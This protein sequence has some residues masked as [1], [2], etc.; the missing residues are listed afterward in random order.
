MTLLCAFFTEERGFI[1]S[2]T[3]TSTAMKCDAHLEYRWE[4]SG[5]TTKFRVLPHLSAIV[6]STGRALV[7]DDAKNVLNR[8]VWPGGISSVPDQL[9]ELLQTW[10]DIHRSRLRAK[11]EDPGDMRAR[12]WVMGFDHAAGRVRFW[13]FD[14]EEAFLAT[15]REP[16]LYLSPGD[17]RLLEGLKER[18]KKLDRDILP[19][20]LHLQKQVADAARERGEA[21]TAIG[22]EVF[23]C[24]VSADGFSVKKLLTFSDKEEL[25]TAIAERAR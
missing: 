19:R 11:G 2:D 25:T 9:P 22:G 10:T 1:A 20:V 8:G 4:P 23:G 18:P 24:E 21:L 12:V 15:E 5:F 3:L 14:S 16:G 7:G 17:D 13:T 6:A